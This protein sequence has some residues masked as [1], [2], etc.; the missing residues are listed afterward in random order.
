MSKVP[1]LATRLLLIVGYI[2]FVIVA[3][4]LM[5]RALSPTGYTTG[6]N[7]LILSGYSAI[8][9]LGLNIIVGYCGLLNLGFA[10]FMLIGAYTAGILMRDFHISFWLALIAALVH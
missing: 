5:Q 7:I 10:G 8:A 9:A 3:P 2:V 6:L 1:P 4:F